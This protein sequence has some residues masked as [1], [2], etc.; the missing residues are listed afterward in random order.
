MASPPIRIVGGA[1]ECPEAKPFPN[2]TGGAGPC[3]AATLV[4]VLFDMPWPPAD[5]TVAAGVDGVAGSKGGRS[6]L[7]SALTEVRFTISGVIICRFWTT[8]IGTTVAFL[9]GAGGFQMI[10]RG[11]GRGGNGG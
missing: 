4:A 7:L 10:G 3:A 1:E 2:F 6:I 11:M 5:G 9:F 8:L